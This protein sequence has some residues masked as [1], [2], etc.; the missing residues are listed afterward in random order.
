MKKTEVNSTLVSIVD[1]KTN[2][3][4]QAVKKL[5][6]INMAKVNILIRLLMMML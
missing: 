2:K 3:I 4:K 1:V 5:Y 6:N